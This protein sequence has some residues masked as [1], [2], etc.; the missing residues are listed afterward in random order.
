MWERHHK[1]PYMSNRLL[2]AS[3]P[4]EVGIQYVW[5]VFVLLNVVDF[6]VTSNPKEH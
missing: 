1:L 4:R 5:L 6:L 2:R 3:K